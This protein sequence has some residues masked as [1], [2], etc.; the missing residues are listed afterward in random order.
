M[1]VLLLGATGRTGARVL[2][3]LLERGVPVRALVRSASSACVISP[4]A[5]RSARISFVTLVGLGTVRSPAG[6]PRA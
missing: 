3:R 2:G 6:R 1:S 4:A 5:K